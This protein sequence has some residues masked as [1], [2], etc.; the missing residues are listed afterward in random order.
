MKHWCLVKRAAVSTVRIA[1]VDT[2]STSPVTGAIFV[3]HTIR[4]LRFAQYAMPIAV[5]R[6]ELSMTS[7]AR[8]TSATDVESSLKYWCTVK[9]AKHT[10]VS[11]A[12]QITHCMLKSTNVIGVGSLLPS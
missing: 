8:C 2:I 6:A 9:F 10:I 5:R 4:K 11:D 3:R 12:L 1:W 7:M